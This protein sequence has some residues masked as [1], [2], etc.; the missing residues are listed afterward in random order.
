MSSGFGCGEVFNRSLKFLLRRYNLVMVT[1]DEVKKILDDLLGFSDYVLEHPADE[2]NGDLAMNAAMVKA[3]KTGISP[4]EVALKMVDMIKESGELGRVV[5]LGKIEVAGPGFINLWFKNEY[6]VKKLGENLEGKNDW[7]KYKR[8][9]IDF[10]SPNIAKRFSVGHLRSTIIGQALFNLYKASGAEVVGDN[11]LGDWGTQF[12]MIIAGAEEEQVEVSKMSIGELEDLY[13][14]F[15]KR[16]EENS[17]LKEKAREAFAR[18]EAGEESARRIWQEAVDVSL[19]ELDKIY[20]K[21]GVSFD[22]ALG[23]S[24]YELMMPEIIKEAVDK[25]VADVG[26]GGAIIVKFEKDGVEYMSP[27]ML[28]KSNGTTTYATRDLAAIKRR[29]T[30]EKMKSDLYIYEVGGEQSLHFKQVFEIAKMLWPEAQKV[31]FKHVSHGQL[32]LPEGKMSTRRGITIKLEDLMDRA[33]EEARSMVKSEGVDFEMMGI[34]AMK[35]NELKRSPQ[36]DYV[37]RWEEALSMEGNS[38]PYINYAYVRANKII[39]GQSLD[40]IEATFEGEEVDL[41][42]FLLRFV[43]GEI[44]RESAKNYSPQLLAGYLFEVAKRFNAFYDHNRVIGDSRENERL[45]L[46]RAVVE[47]LGNGMKVLGILLVDKM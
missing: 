40:G 38:A 25:G 15:N 1:R 23:E 32:S 27:A 36:S 43:D 11:H 47:V 18:L 46:V 33:T 28:R 41:A 8:V 35:Y 19:L 17:D 26:E 14:R 7:F 42:R 31:D 10:S 22:Y 44:T 2:L 21:L 34:N 45:I 5:D 4:R 39:I 30:D 16:V 6:L 37:F 20:K 3:K 13:V 12:G 29:L 24:A 9:L